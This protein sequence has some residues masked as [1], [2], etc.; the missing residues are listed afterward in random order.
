VIVP[1]FIITLNWA[2]AVSQAHNLDAQLSQ[3]EAKSSEGFQFAIDL[4]VQIHIPDTQAPYVISMVGSVPNLVNEVLQAAVGNHFRNKLQS[5][6]A[7]KFI[8]SREEVQQ[9]AFDYVKAELAKYRVETRGVYIQ[10]VALPE[11]LVEVLTQREIAN[12]EVATYQMQKAAQDQRIET[13][14]AKGTADMQADLAKSQVGVDIQTNRAAARKM[15]AAGEATY[16]EQTGAAQGAQVR[17]VGLARAEA[18][19]RQ[20]AAL[21]ASGTALVNSVEALSRSTVPFMPNTLVMGGGGTVDGLLAL[22][23]R[24][25]DAN[26]SLRPPAGA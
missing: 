7:V 2:D 9:G 15:E 3:I 4:Q 11:Q 6:P 23:M 21:G 10:A 24:Q 16:I 5:M 19:E 26:L 12:Q 18:Y 17:S 1:T 25:V 22:M 8:S 20:V 14:K 13:E